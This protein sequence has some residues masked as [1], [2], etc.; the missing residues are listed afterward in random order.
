MTTM[1]EQ[2]TQQASEIRAD[3]LRGMK[4]TETELAD[5]ERLSRRLDFFISSLFIKS[6]FKSVE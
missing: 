5:N 1:I 4:L 2:L 6:A 3:I